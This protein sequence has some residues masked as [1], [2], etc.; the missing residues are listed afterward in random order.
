LRYFQLPMQWCSLNVWQDV[1]SSCSLTCFLPLHRYVVLIVKPKYHSF[2]IANSVAWCLAELASEG[3][4]K[5]IITQSDKNNL[6]TGVVP[7]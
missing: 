7:K 4:H 2:Y 5:W 1:P 6:Y 3:G